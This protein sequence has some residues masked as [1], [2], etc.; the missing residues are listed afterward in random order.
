MISR[1]EKT[2]LRKKTFDGKIRKCLGKGQVVRLCPR[3][4]RKLP[5]QREHGEL[6]SGGTVERDAF[7]KQRKSFEHDDSIETHLG[8]T[9]RGMSLRTFQ[10]V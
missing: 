2:Y 5:R 6:M 10:E 7:H 9:L 3:T 4:H 1:S 8:D